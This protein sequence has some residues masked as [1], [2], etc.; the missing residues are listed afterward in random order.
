MPRPCV[1]AKLVSPRRSRPDQRTA[2]GSSF[3]PGAGEIN[4]M[5]SS[6]VFLHA[7]KF[8]AHQVE[9]SP[10]AGNLGVGS[11]GRDVFHIDM[12]EFAAGLGQFDPNPRSHRDTITAER[13]TA[14]GGEP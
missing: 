13:G 4:A 5:I 2:S 6:I 14:S 12:N 7:L 11:D 10:G 8:P 3:W 9:L 1:Q